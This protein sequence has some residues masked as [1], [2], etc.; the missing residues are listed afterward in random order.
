MVKPVAKKIR[1]KKMQ[2]LHIGDIVYDLHREHHYL[3][4][5]KKA[6]EELVLG[7]FEALL[8]RLG[9]GEPVNIR[10][11]GTFKSKFYKGRPSTLPNSS[12]DQQFEGKY[13]I[14]FKSS[15][16]AKIKL[17]ELITQY[18]AA[19]AAAAD[20]K[21]P[22]KGLKAVSS[23]DLDDDEDDDDEKPAKK[24]KKVKASAEDA[25]K[26]RGRPKKAVVEVAEDLDEETPNKAKRAKAVPSE[27]STE[28]EDGFEHSKSPAPKKGKSESAALEKTKSKKVKKAEK[29]EE[30]PKKTKPVPVPT[31][32]LPAE[33]EDDEEDLDELDDLEDDETDDLDESEDDLEDDEDDLEDD[34]E[35][36][37]EEE[38]APA[39]K[40]SKKAN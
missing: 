38:P 30:A 33:A 23:V 14:R 40:K 36:E 6:L 29:A 5:S 9:R 39:P 22:P 11:F 19:R 21:L 13:I 26:K 10:Q 17:N 15:N 7:T 24:V 1:K 3:G 27:E 34:E 28:V 32:T 37:D 25:P 4:L 8:T 20:G 35:D 18:S 2:T 12:K 16:K 31:P